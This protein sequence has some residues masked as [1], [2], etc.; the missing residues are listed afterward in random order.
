MDATLSS[1]GARIPLTLVKGVDKVVP[2]TLTR[3]DGTPVDLTGALITASIVDALTKNEVAAITGTVA[4][5][6]AGKGLLT[7][8]AASLET[9]APRGKYEWLSFYELGGLTKHLFW[10]SVSVLQGSGT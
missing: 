10:G 6:P 8:T 3:K 1:L 4:D 5:G 7:I 9:L 2:F